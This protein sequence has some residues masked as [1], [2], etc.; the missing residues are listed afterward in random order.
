[1]RMSGGV[2]SMRRRSSGGVSPVRTATLGAGRSTPAAAARRAD[3]RERRAQVALDVVVERLERRD[4]EHAQALA[5]L[6]QQAVEEP[7]ERRQRLA[8]ARRRA[9]EHVL[10]RRDR[11]PAQGLRGRGRR[12]ARS[13]TSGVRGARSRRVRQRWRWTSPMHH[14]R[15]PSRRLPQQQ[16]ERE[17][18]A[19]GHDHRRRKRDAS[20]DHGL[21]AAGSGRSR[22]RQQRAE[23]AGGQRER[24]RAIAEGSG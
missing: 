9:H 1:M 13:R 20:R 10:A 2:R 5:G 16:V 14:T 6:R 22:A 8:G 23:R 11:R 19:G 15:R 4:V 21:L 18:P 17:Q 7:Q 12:R 24:R 3:A